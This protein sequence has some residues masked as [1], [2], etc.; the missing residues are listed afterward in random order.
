[1]DFTSFHSGYASKSV[2]TSMMSAA[3]AAMV[4]EPSVLSAISLPSSVRSLVGPAA[5]VGPEMAHVHQ[6]GRPDVAGVDQ[7]L[8]HVP[9]Q[10]IPRP[11]LH[12]EADQRGGA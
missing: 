7:R 5:A 12:D 6:G 11:A 8:V 3:D 1:M 2:M 10:R 4:A 9:E